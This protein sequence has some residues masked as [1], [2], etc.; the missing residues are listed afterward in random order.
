MRHT[1]ERL[2]SGCF[3]FVALVLSATTTAEPGVVYRGGSGIG[4]GRH[5]VLV[6]GDEEYRSEEAM[7]MLG[8]LLSEYYG[9]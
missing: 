1:S 8:R 5:V 3:C 4:A 9:L 7:P 6:S 2:L